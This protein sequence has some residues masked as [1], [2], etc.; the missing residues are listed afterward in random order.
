MWLISVLVVVPVFYVLSG[1]QIPLKVDE[2]LELFFPK[3]A[4]PSEQLIA[5]GF[6]AGAFL[7]SSPLHKIARYL[8][9]V[10][11]ELGH[12]FTAGILG[13]RPKNITI[14]L[15]TSGLAIYEPPMNWG[16]LRAT[17]VSLA[18]YPASSIAALAAVK[19]TQ[20]GHP[21]AWFAFAVGTLAVSIVLLIRNIWGFIWTAGVVA[22]SYFGA[23]YIP[24]EM[25]GAVV[26]GVAGYLAIEAY[27]HAYTQ[28]LIIR[29]F[30]GSGADAEKVARSWRMNGPFVGFLHLL[31]VTAISAYSVYLAINPYWGEIEDWVQEFIK[32]N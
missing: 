24:L 22:A 8:P 31:S 21:Q 13:G 16:K 11:H 3:D 25:I 10:V 27:R 30:P 29:K 19:I 14:S 17:L 32:V 23:P 9:T 2:Q 5:L 15:D 12:A 7:A 1:R 6:I 4:V 28:W 20:E 26:S 18:G